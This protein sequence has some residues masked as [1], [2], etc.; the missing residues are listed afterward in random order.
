MII[1]EVHTE[2]GLILAASL[3]SLLPSIMWENTQFQIHS[4]KIRNFLEV[5]VLKVCKYFP[6]DNNFWTS[7]DIFLLNAVVN[8]CYTM[9]KNRWKTPLGPMI[10]ELRYYN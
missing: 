8:V 2:G 3:S 9:K 6:V 5:S 1:F 10:V 4:E 7:V